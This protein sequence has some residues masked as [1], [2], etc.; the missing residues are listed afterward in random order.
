MLSEV[1]MYSEA[2][3]MTPSVLGALVGP[4]L[5]NTSCDQVEYVVIKER[6]HILLENIPILAEVIIFLFYRSN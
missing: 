4:A 1:E 2:N 6:F 3:F 5:Y